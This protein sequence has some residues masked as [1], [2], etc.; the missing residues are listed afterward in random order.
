MCEVVQSGR[1]KYASYFERGKIIGFHQSKKTR[2]EIAEITGIGLRRVKRIIKTCKN[3]GEVSTS[4]NK[5]GREK[6]LKLAGSK[7]SEATGEEK[8]QK[9][10]SRV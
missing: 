9:I 7:I 8:S 4:R 3:S 6:T 2:K 5:C 1:G 10:G